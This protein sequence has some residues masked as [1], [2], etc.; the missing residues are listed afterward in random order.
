M[1]ARNG[2]ALRFLDLG[3]QATMQISASSLGVTPQTTAIVL[4][5]M[6]YVNEF[7]GW[8]RDVATIFSLSE[9]WNANVELK[10][11]KYEGAFVKGGSW[12]SFK[13]PE[14]RKTFQTKTWHHLRM[15]IT[16]SGYEVRLDGKLIAS[17][18]TGDLNN[19]GNTAHAVTLTMG[20]FDGWIDEVVIRSENATTATAASLTP[21]G[22]GPQGFRMRVAGKAGNTYMIQA[23][24]DNRSW[25]NLGQVTLSASTGEFTDTSKTPVVRMYRALKL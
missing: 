10:E 19:W 18:A 17:V 3:D 2:S 16:R 13:A 15:A 14:L 9:A 8:D 25:N 6:I 12:W 23:S 11:D 22:G 4:E 7:K 5:G 20:N 21:I 24:Q 1:A